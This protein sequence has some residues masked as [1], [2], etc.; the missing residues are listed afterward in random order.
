MLRIIKRYKIKIVLIA[1]I[2]MIIQ[3]LSD[4]SLPTLTSNII[5]NGISKGN[6][7]YIWKM[8]LIMLIFTIIS[9]LAAIINSYISAKEAHRIGYDLR[10]GV[11]KRGINFSRSAF[12]SIGA[13]SLINRS[14][15]DVNQVQL[16]LLFILRVALQAPVMALGAAFLS[17]R[18][19]PKLSQVFLIAIPIVLIASYLVVHFASPLFQKMQK[20]TDKLNMIFREGLT[21]VRVIRAFNKSKHEEKRFDKTNRTYLGIGIKANIL[22]GLMFPLMLLILNGT[23]IFII[24]IGAFLVSD[25]QVQ[26]G[27]LVAFITYS[28]MLLISFVLLTV[29]FILLPRAQVS[30]KRINQVLDTKDPI[31]NPQTAYSLSQKPITLAYKKVTFKYSQAKNTVLDQIN[32][33]A[34]AGQ[35]IAIIGGTGSGKSTIAQLLLRYYD[36]TRGTIQ[37]DKKDIR[38]LKISDLRQKISY[39]PQTANLF[40]GTIRSNLLFG[41]HQASD[42]DLWQALKIAQ[43]SDFVSN[44]DNRVEQGGNNFSGGQKQRLCIARA[45]VKKPQ[46]YIFDDAFSALDFKTDSALRRALK[47]VIKKSIVLIIAQRVNTVTNADLILVL[48][49]GQVV[50]KGTD[51]QLRKSNKTYQAI[52]RSQEKTRTRIE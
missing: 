45:I 42:K 15:N 52:I 23:S 44:L 47:S 6:I 41:N 24:G 33:S 49:K 35:T 34:K 51:K 8:G 40:E 30:A 5:D 36:V 20:L 16:V 4:L 28:A 10:E 25:R 27:N 11:F 46:I 37:I 39:V 22:T 18:I 31:K 29:I 9:L 38:N 12:E 1:L 17:F 14:T 3:V 48:E 43:T 21:G 26:V 32:F 50:G 19:S 7:K 2:I 13:A